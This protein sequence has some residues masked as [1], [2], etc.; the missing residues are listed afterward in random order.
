[1]P[2]PKA[3]SPR[4]GDNLR[5]LVVQTPYH[6]ENEA[7]G[8][9]VSQDLVCSW[10]PNLVRIAT[11]G[12][13]SCYYHGIL[14]GCYVPYQNN[15]SFGYRTRIVRRL[16]MDLAYLLETP[17]PEDPQ[18]RIVYETAVGGFFPSLGITV[19]NVDFSL[20]GLQR[21]IASTRDSGDEVYGYI[22]EQLGINVYV[23]IGTTE[24]LFPAITVIPDE[25]LKPSVVIVGNTSH[26]EV[27]ALKTKD[28]LQ[29]LFHPE[30]P[31]ILAIKQKFRRT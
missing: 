24:D 8:D 3:K 28:G 16:R 17:D 20:Q 29:T 7:V 23:L 12:D 2:V 9:D 21:E 11:I 13:G 18:G 1:M 19:G 22:A 5:I 4:P 30:D 26:Y 14:K 31:F 6:I 15:N 25:V 27:V 10:Y